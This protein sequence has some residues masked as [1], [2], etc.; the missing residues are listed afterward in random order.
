MAEIIVFR[1][2]SNSIGNNF[3][4][5]VKKLDTLQ[6]IAVFKVWIIKYELEKQTLINK[7]DEIKNRINKIAEDWLQ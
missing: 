6:Q 7:V 3:N 4:Q 1:T 2:E 5:A